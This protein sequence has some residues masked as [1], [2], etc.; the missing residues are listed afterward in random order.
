M[1]GALHLH[2]TYSD[3][4]FSLPELRAIYLAA[5]CQFAC[6]TD[7]ADWFDESTLAAYIEECDALSDDRFRLVAGLEFPCV[8]RMHIVGYGVTRLVNSLD[9]PDVIRHIGACGGV[10]VIAHPK[11]LHF[12]W[13]AGFTALPD[14]LEVWNSKYD[15]RY[16]PRP[17]TFALLRRLRAR[18]SDLRAFYAQDLHWR[19]QYRGLLV[20]VEAEALTRDAVLGALRAGAYYGEKDGTRFPSDGAVP[21]ALLRQMQQA[22]R[23]SDRLR[24]VMASVKR[25]ADWLGLRVPAGVKAQARKVM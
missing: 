1:K 12:E 25:A 6:V 17:H 10:S 3:G 4:D 23:R 19:T 24:A 2:S 21:D 18:R 11:D 15:G 13:I 7:H 14:G 20:H 9:P 16:A 8:D 22:H 5:G